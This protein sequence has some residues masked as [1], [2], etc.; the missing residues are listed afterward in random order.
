MKVGDLVQIQYQ[1]NKPQK[2][3]CVVLSIHNNGE[4]AD[5]LTPAGSMTL[6]TRDLKRINNE[7]R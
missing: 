4:T 1:G 6:L 2:S 5:V 7:S 3:A